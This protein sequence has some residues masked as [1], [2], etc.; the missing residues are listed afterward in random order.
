V[1]EGGRAIFAGDE[2]GEGVDGDVGQAEVAARMGLTVSGVKSRIQ[3][4]RAKL[5]EELLACCEFAFDGEGKISGYWKTGGRC[6]GK[7]C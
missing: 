2:S 1:E 4:G 6:A 7:N 3:R 5:R